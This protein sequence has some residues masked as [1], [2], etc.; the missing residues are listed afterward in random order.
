MNEIIAAARARRLTPDAHVI[1]S[2]NHPVLR[3]W[4]RLDEYV[5][6]KL[7]GTDPT[8]QAWVI[9]RVATSSGPAWLAWMLEDYAGG[10][11][12]HDAEPSWNP[13]RAA[14]IDYV[15]NLAGFAAA[16]INP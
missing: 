6:P 3:N 1:T 10:R 5:D 12:L 2:H 14:A 13:T 9:E 11:G 4:R 8:G 16:A 15:S 7:V